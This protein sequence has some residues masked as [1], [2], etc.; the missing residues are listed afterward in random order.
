MSLNLLVAKNNPY[1]NFYQGDINWNYGDE[2]SVVVNGLI[3]YRIGNIVFCEMKA[4]NDT[5]GTVVAG[6]KN[7]FSDVGDIPA[8]YLPAVS[9]DRELGNTSQDAAGTISS[10]PYDLSST[11]ILRKYINADKNTDITA[12][13]A[14]SYPYQLAMWIV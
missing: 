11:G 6:V 3:L 12:S 10:I 4:H 2:K 13:T 8:D 9:A 7:V 1:S 5:S 14:Y